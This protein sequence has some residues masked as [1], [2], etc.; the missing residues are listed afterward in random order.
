LELRTFN[1]TGLS[2][3][4]FCFLLQPSGLP[5]RAVGAVGVAK[6]RS[7]RWTSQ[8]DSDSFE[9]NLPTN[10]A[11]EAYFVARSEIC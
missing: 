9:P 4:S 1:T 11:D 5:S 2:G 6:N 10:F 3:G 8:R 7:F